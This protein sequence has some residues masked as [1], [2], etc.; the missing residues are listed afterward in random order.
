MKATGLWSF[1]GIG[2]DSGLDAE[3]QLSGFMVLQLEMRVA[4][5][6]LEPTSGVDSASFRSSELSHPT[7]LRC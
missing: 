3:V 6:S 4:A 1:A 5:C 2:L 7:V